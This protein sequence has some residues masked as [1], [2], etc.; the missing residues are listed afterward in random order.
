LIKQIEQRS[1]LAD[2]A[3]NPL[4][5]CMM[6]TYHKNNPARSLP[7]AR[8]RLYQGFCQMLLADRPLSKKMAIMLPAEESQAV[9]QRVALDMVQ[10]DCIALSVEEMTQ[11]VERCVGEC[12]ESANQAL[13]SASG[14]VKEIEEVSEL[15]VRRQA[16]DD[17]E[18]SHRSFQEYLAAVEVKRRQEE[19][20]LVAL[21]KEWRDTAVLYAAMA[22]P[23]G[24]IEQLCEKGGREALDLAYD[25]WLENQRGV[26]TETF[27]RLQNLR[28]A[29]LEQY[30]VAGDWKEADMYNY[31]LMIQVLGKRYGHYFTAEE[32]IT[33]PCAD[34][35][36]I[37][38]LW[39]LYSQG[40]FGF[41]VQKEIYVCCGGEL[42]GEYY[43]THLASSRI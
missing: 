32:L 15:F 29:Q 1:E 26:P 17:V 21:G 9:L 7:L 36:R 14:F 4:L 23:T 12:L 22:N 40:R 18:F 5:L 30:M 37:D 11:L 20:L 28:Y 31:R 13:V 43:R 19:S 24:L 27:E 10:R 16:S 25:C 42:D 39:V 38:G 33:F 35:L 2:M 6:A 8:H 41:S 3:D 34:L